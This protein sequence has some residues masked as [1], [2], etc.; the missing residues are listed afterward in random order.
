M[1]MTAASNDTA[2]QPPAVEDGAWTVK[3]AAGFLGLSTKTVYRMAAE[4][5][6]P[7]LRLGGSVRFSP[8][9]LAEWR[10]AQE[11]GGAPR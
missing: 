2:S 11:H 3:E 6:L 4:G 1:M 9:R 5:T 8:K 7:C 10:A